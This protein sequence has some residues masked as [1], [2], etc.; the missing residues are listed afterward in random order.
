MSRIL[1]KVAIIAVVSTAFS[2]A[3]TGTIMTANGIYHKIGYVIAAVCPLLI[4]PPI[5]LIVLWQSEKL[6]RALE[7]L[8]LVKE[9]LE[10]TNA[11]LFEKSTRDSMTGML[12]REAFFNHVNHVRSRQ[13]CSLLIIDVDHFKKINDVHGHY[14]GD[15]ALMAIAR[16]IC[17]CMGIDGIT[18][19]IGGEEFGVCLLT[20]NPSTVEAIAE[21][22]RREVGQ[23]V[24]VTTDDTPVALSVSIGGSADISSDTVADHFQIADRKLYEAKR[25]GRNCVFIHANFREA[26]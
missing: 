3:I 14:V 5:S 9:E 11:K 10:A 4:S 16:C 23:L 2:L 20:D 18:G 19:R 7:T 12:N 21:D 6:K 13:A 8:R 24:F 17:D 1:A 15:A 22:I 25:H 26:A